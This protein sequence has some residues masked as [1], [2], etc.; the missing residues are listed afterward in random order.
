MTG[1][2]TAVPVAGG[3]LAELRPARRAAR[4]KLL[5]AIATA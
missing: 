4:L 1:G 5:D 2:T 3:P